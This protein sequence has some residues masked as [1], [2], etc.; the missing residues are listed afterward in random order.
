MPSAMSNFP[1][2][3]WLGENPDYVGSDEA[4]LGLHGGSR[5]GRRPSVTSWCRPPHAE[6]EIWKSRLTPQYQGSSENGEAQK[7][8]ER[9]IE[10]GEYFLIPQY[11]ASSTFSRATQEAALGCPSNL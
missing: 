6:T 11:M 3:A 2:R 5:L 4:V 10:S 8:I 9:D 7:I 1:I